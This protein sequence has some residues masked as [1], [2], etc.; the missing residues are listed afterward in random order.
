M[1]IRLIC[2]PKCGTCRT[3]EKHLKTK[4]Y[5]FEYQDIKENPPT[6]EELK[7]YYQDSQLPI[8]RFFNTSGN[9]YRALDLAQTF[10]RYSEKE[11]LELLS[12]DGMLIKRPLLII[13]NKFVTMGY[14]S[15]LWDQL[16]P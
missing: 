14:N 3:A 6:Y 2:Y 12:Q 4:N 11:L 16:I 8:K 5:S 13:D 10:D 9:S 7:Q 1:K 15:E